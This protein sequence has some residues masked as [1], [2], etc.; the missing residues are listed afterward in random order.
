M[1][2]TWF[3][4]LPPTLA[5]WLVSTDIE[6][7]KIAL[8]MAKQFVDINNT[9]LK[10]MTTAT[11]SASIGVA[12]EEYVADIINE[13]LR[14]RVPCKIINV[15]KTSKSGDI[16]IETSSVKILIEV[17]NYSAS[18]NHAEVTKFHRDIGAGNIHGGIFIS[19]R[20]GIQ[21]FQS[22]YTLRYENINGILI[23]TVYVISENPDVIMS[24]IEM[25]VAAATDSKLSYRSDIA[26]KM[27]SLENS[28][29]ALNRTASDMAE[30]HIGISTI[31]RNEYN[32]LVGTKAELNR[33][34]NN[35]QDELSDVRTI[36]GG[37]DEFKTVLD[38]YPIDDNTRKHINELIVLFPSDSAPSTSTQWKILKTKM[39]HIESGYGFTFTKTKT[40]FNISTNITKEMVTDVIN[41]VFDH[42]TT[43]GTLISIN[44]VDDTVKYIAGLIKK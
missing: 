14:E 42:S 24:A 5:A 43:S 23:P 10:T 4:K 12:G 1:E 11:S 15:A 17:K 35:L 16:I 8:G 29:C 37:C 9:T 2:S 13:H 19:L 7:V 39:V 41:N 33:A 20:S 38:T 25:V 18:V 26:N 34:F 31:L 44:V 27:K 6:Q 40:S 32:S 36:T 28:L 30:G 3:Q 21:R 22:N